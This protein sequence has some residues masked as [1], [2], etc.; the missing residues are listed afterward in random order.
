M[1]ALNAHCAGESIVENIQIYGEQDLGTH[2]P[3][4]LSTQS[5]ESVIIFRNVDMRAGTRH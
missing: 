4:R 2:G 1:Q 5:D 3:F